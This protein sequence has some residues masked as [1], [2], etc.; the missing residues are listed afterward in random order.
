MYTSARNMSNEHPKLMKSLGLVDLTL[1]LVVAIV[2]LNLVPAIARTGVGV[3]SLWVVAFFL[4]FLPQAIAVVEL[5]TR[6]PQEGGIYVWSKIPF[7]DLQGFLS[8]WCYWTNNLFYIP[9]LLFYFVGCT[10]FIVG[11]KAL[12]LADDVRFM[13]AAAVILLW[14]IVSLNVAGPRFWKWVQNLGGLGTFAIV[15]IIIGIAFTSHASAGAA[16]PIS[17]ST[18]VPSATDWGTVSMLGVVCFAFVGLELGSV[19][20]E[21]VKRP[22]SDI[23]KAVLLAGPCCVLLYLICTLALQVSVPIKDIGEFSGLLQ[24]I[25]VKDRFGLLPILAFL[26]SLSVA[27]ATSAWFAG[28]ARIPFVMGIGHFLPPK[29]GEIHPRYQTPHVALIVEGVVMTVI[30]L[31]NSLGATMHEVYSVLLKTAVVIQLIPF[32]YMFAALVKVCLARGEYADTEPFF[33]SSWLCVG[34]GVVGFLI[35]AM[36]IIL[37]FFPQEVGENVSTYVLKILLGCVSFLLPA[38]FLYFKRAKSSQAG[39]I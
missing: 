2:N 6:F 23:P 22:K 12:P 16:N 17:L 13:S 7:G 11:E 4:F 39:Q 19:M 1:L 10:L 37:A 27:G 34:A 30:I 8:G 9:T 3:I 25:G 28:S 26:L 35:T 32:L 5:S 21:E 24:V 29:F 38:L 33:K 31:L 36:G 18:L 14:L 20:G 15:V